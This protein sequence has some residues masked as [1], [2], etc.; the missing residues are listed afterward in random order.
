[1]HDRVKILDK[2]INKLIGENNGKVPLDSFLH[3]H[4]CVKFPVKLPCSVGGPCVNLVQ[5]ASLI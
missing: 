2:N 4:V 3:V 1:M 5:V